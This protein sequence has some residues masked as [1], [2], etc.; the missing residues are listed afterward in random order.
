LLAG[1][2]ATASCGHDPGDIIGPSD[3]VQT[4]SP[5][6]QS[7]AIGGRLAFVRRIDGLEAIH[8]ATQTGVRPLAMGTKPRWSPNGDRLVYQ[9]HVDIHVMRADGSGQRRLARGAS[10]DW[11]PDGRK[12]VF[13][14]E[15]GI[16]VVSADGTGET[17]VLEHGAG[18]L[19]EVY[20]P[21]WS[22]DGRSIAFLE[23][24][25]EWEG[26][27]IYVMNADGTD[28]RQRSTPGGV[29]WNQMDPA[30][31]PD[32]AEIAFTMGA[33]GIGV[34]MADGSSWRQIAGDRVFGPE[35]S[36]DG[37]LVTLITGPGVAPGGG[38]ETRIVL[39]DG[40]PSRQVILPDYAG[41]STYADSYPAWAP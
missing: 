40:G 27:I 28:L 8:V 14:G 25:G 19:G 16:H 10:P 1:T 3:V 20:A 21:R 33:Y 34:I 31:S 9:L 12:I 22:P 39:H 6:P 7:L 35:W 4:G 2:L 11:S 37:L 41:S 29:S 15:R 17:T 38:F 5:G 26:S 18:G 23:Y 24:R 32:G 36:Q 30:W 13:V